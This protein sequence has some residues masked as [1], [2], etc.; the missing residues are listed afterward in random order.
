MVP[1]GILTPWKLNNYIMQ[2]LYLLKVEIPRQMSDFIFARK[3]SS[4]ISYSLQFEKTIE[5]AEG[6]FY[7]FIL[8]RN[9]KFL[10]IF[11]SE[12]NITNFT[13]Y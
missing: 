9:N 10:L 1:Y 4:K 11:C 2:Y 13:G 5:Q 8:M 3:K 6:K 7:S 12:K